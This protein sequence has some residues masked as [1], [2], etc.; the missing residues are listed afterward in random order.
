MASKRVTGTPSPT[1]QLDS[2][3]AYPERKRAGYVQGSADLEYGEVDGFQYGF[4]STGARHK[5]SD[6]GRKVR[7]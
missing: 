3:F 2:Q 6:L 5:L 7:G 4:E 1:P